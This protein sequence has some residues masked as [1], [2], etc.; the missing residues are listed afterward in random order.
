[1]I[2]HL[3]DIFKKVKAIQGKVE[4]ESLRDNFFDS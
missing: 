2:E 3:R 1:M 4:V